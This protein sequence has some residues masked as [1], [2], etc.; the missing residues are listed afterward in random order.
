M[1]TYKEITESK[2]T[3]AVI[4]DFDTTPEY[5]DSTIKDLKKLGIAAKNASPRI[6]PNIIVY[7][8]KD[9]SQAQKFI[10]YMKK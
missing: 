2:I 5:M 1:K 3:E 6:G 8:L 10:K 9:K 7:T 4:S